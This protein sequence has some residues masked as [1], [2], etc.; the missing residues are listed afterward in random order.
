M[1]KWKIE[2]LMVLAAIVIGCSIW[3]FVAT[4]PKRAAKKE[5][6]QLTDFVQRQALEIAAIEQA[7]KLGNYK[8]QLATAQKPIEPIVDPDDIQ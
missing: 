1:K 3:A 2:I 8:R 4:E 7:S 5:L 6:K